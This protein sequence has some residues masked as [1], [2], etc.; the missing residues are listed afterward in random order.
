[1][2]KTLKRAKDPGSALTH[3][4]GMILAIVIAIPLIAKAYMQSG[5]V[6][7]I[8]LSVFAL[9][10]ILLYTAS[11][12]YHTFD[13]SDKINKRLKKFDHMMIYFLIAGTY[14]PICLIPLKGVIGYAMLAIIWSMAIAG[15]IITAFF[16]DT[17]KWVS[18]MI[19]IIMGWICVIAFSPLVKVL[20]GSGI[21]WLVAGGVIYTIGGIIYALHLP[22]F[23]MKHK[24]F[25]S[26]EIFHLFCLG[27]SGCHVVFMFRYIIDMP[28]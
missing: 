4:I 20:P 7:I 16:V 13:L 28:L 1:M 2:V 19:Y 22:I 24:Y 10:L 15:I 12:V 25:G 21:G 5:Y 26:H 17:P 8:A 18:S 27:G 6:H 9:S 14:T 11:T 3:F 23:N